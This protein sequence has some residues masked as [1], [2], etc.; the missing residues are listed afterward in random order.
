MHKILEYIKTIITNLISNA[1]WCILSA[2]LANILLWLPLIKVVCQNIKNS[3]YSISLYDLIY[4]GISFILMFLLI[5]IL[6]I[7]I[8]KQQ[9][10]DNS[11]LNTNTITTDLIFNSLEI[12]LYFKNRKDIFTHATYNCIANKEGPIDDF[13]QD[14][15]WTG[16]KY[17]YTK[18]IKSDDSYILNDSNRTASPY[19]YIINFNKTFSLGDKLYFMLET[20]V[21]DSNFTMVPVFSHLIKNQTINFTIHLTVPEDLVINV[22]P[23]VY[24]DIART[25]KVPHNIM[26][27]KKTVGNLI[28]YSYTIHNPNLLNNYCIEWNFK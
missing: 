20:S 27:E 1:I 16:G 11:N 6:I 7:V 13:K 9:H 5:I 2:L 8:F 21:N 24:R 12:E 4:V 26:L 28:Q 15:I 23:A 19:T 22:K 18:I 14:I 17:N 10:K 25:I 3:K